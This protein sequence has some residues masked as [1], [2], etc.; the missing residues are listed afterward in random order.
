[1]PAPRIISIPNPHSE[2]R[3]EKVDLLVVHAMGEWVVLDGVYRHCTDHLR[4]VG[5]SVHAFCL[6]DGRIVSSVDTARVA[7]HA[8]AYN[9][10]SIGLELVVE[11]AHD[12]QSLFARIDDTAEP[13]YTAAQYQAAGWWFRSQADRYGLAFGHV[14]PHSALDDRKR[15]PGQAFDWEAF[16]RAFAAGADR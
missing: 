8:R 16:R 11:G 10:R 15:D 6:P 13:P 7:H 12:D 1:M 2:P 9:P 4:E 5:L 14:T 3:R